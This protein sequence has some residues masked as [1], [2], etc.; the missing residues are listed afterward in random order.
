MHFTVCHLVN[1]QATLSCPCSSTHVLVLLVYMSIACMRD[2]CCF[3]ASSHHTHCSAVNS[4]GSHELMPGEGCAVCGRL[5]CC[6]PCCPCRG[7]QGPALLGLRLCWL[8]SCSMRLCMWC[9]LTMWSMVVLS[10]SA[11]LRA[12]QH[13]KQSGVQ[14]SAEKGIATLRRLSWSDPASSMSKQ[15]TY[16]DAVT[17]MD[18]HARYQIQAHYQVSILHSG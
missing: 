5:C 14:T 2:S 8:P 9:R 3:L 17:R 7:L 4:C 10:A 6:C 15:L 16:I 1:N 12:L 13:Y 18:C 11:R